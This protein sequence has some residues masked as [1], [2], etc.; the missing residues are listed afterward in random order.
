MKEREEDDA[1]NKKRQ[2]GDEIE[3]E[4]KTKDIGN[5]KDERRS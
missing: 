3:E 5:K 4:R 1:K 2:T